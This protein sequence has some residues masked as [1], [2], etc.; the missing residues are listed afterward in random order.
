MDRRT[1]P[2]GP[3]GDEFARNARRRARARRR[4]QR[5]LVIRFFFFIMVIVVMIIGGAFL[6]KRYSPSKEKADLNEYY[7]ITGENQ[8]G[9]TVNG[10]VIHA[11]SMIAD[12]EPYLEYSAVADWLNDR[13]YIDFHENLLLYTLPEGTVTAAQGGS[14]YTL[15][16]EKQS[17]DYVIFK[18]E[19]ETAYIALDF[20]Q[21]YTNMEYKIYDSPKRVAITSEWGKIKTVEA[22]K[23]TQVR[24]LAGVKS[25]IL[26]ELSKGE[27]VTFLEDE[28]KWRKVCTEDG[29]VGYTTKSALEEP[30]SE[31][32]TREFKEQV[33][34][35]ISKDYTINLAWHQ[36]TSSAANEMLGQLIA[37][38]KGLTTV[39]PTWFTVADVQGNMNSLASASY[40]EQAHQNGLEVWALV[41]DFDGGIGSQEESY[42]LLS[43]TSRRAN[44]INQLIAEATSVGVDG[45]NVDF[46]QISKECGEHYIQFIRELSLECEKH[47]LVLSVDNYVPRGFNQQYHRKEQ[48]VV[49]DYVIIMGYD[50][51]YAGSY[52][53]GSV[54]SYGFV[55]E[56]I[57]KTLEEVPADKVIN[58]VPFYTRLWKETSKSEQELAAEQG[59]EAAQYPVKVESKTYSMQDAAVRVSEA[60]ASVSWDDDTKQNYAQWEEE[61]STYKIWLED[62]AS[63]EEKLKLMKE[64]SL[65]GTA[66]WKL[67]LETA[68]VW[69]VIEKYVK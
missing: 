49:A 20:V 26:T 2:E 30:K 37:G 31:K 62:A 32:V 53:S 58:A 66:A 19:G 64:Y 6:W 39:S 55:E 59:T 13:F 23:D 40:V 22:K 52:E 27:K 29:F 5:K 9:I 67:G 41:R 28:G 48:G 69:N 35:H 50:E 42:E 68:D 43:Y 16:G 33:Y 36:V 47:N 11:K 4:R 1:R 60:G 15:E 44:L 34:D 8:L 61:G 24:R 57:K 18:S 51:H 38:T 65:A 45:I 21:Q 3:G 10:E 63:V 7:G 25:P 54:A 14:D 12:G 46:E 17:K 56:G